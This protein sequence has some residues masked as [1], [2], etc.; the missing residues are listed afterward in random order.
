MAKLIK[1]NDTY[2]NLDAVAAIEI[3]HYWNYS[4]PYHVA[5]HT[6]SD[7]IKEELTES[8]GKRIEALLKER[9]V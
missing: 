2:V 4:K 7:T 8:D 6:G 5:I 1:I 9:L 3:K